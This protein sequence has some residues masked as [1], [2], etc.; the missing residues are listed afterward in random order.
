MAALLT[1]AVDRLRRLAGQTAFRDATDCQ[2][3]E[4]FAATGD[5]AAFAALVERHGS[6][7][8]G[9]CRRV[10]GHA[11]DA[12]DAFQATFLVLARKAGRLPWKESIKNWLH[13]VA[14]RV[15][16]KARCQGLRR[17]KKERAVRETAAAQ[18][19][20]ASWDDLRGV[21]DEELA[22]LPAKYRAPL[23]LCYLEGKTRDEAAEELGWTP[24]SVKGRLERGRDL[25][26][27]RL[28]A[29]GVPLSA[30]L[31]ASFLAETTASAAVPPT[32]AAATVTTGVSFSAGSLAAVSQPVLNLAQGVLNAMLIAKIKLS[33][34]ALTL[35]AV[36][37]L[38]GWA[39]DRAFADRG[40]SREEGLQLTGAVQDQEKPVQKE[41][42][43]KDKDA[44]KDGERKEKDGVRKKDGE[45]KEDVKKDRPREVSGIR[46]ILKSLDLAKGVMKVVGAGDGNRTEQTYNLAGKDVKVTTTTETPLKLSDLREGLMLFLQLNNQDDV[47][48]IQVELPRLFTFLTQVDAEKKQVTLRIEREQKTFA[49]APNAKLLIQ[50]REA[51]LE[52]FRV[53][54]KVQLQL[55]LDRGTV[56]AMSLTTKGPRDGEGAKG[57]REGEG[58]GRPH[59]VGF[60]FGV[61]PGADG[62]KL[63]VLAGEEGD[64]EPRTLLVPKDLKIHFK[65]ERLSQEVPLT[66]LKK[67]VRLG[68]WLDKD[69]KTVTRLEALAPVLRNA[70]I[71]GIDAG[72]KKI[73]IGE[74]TYTLAP[75]A[76]IVLGRKQVELA[77]VKEGDRATVVLSLDR[78]Q[79]I[80]LMVFRGDG[81]GREE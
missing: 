14:Y 29:R 67:G 52:D 11:H 15:A 28:L 23:L 81:E 1:T 58:P 36:L 73:T 61:Q 72:G 4:R 12:E 55:S 60:V 77:A 21:L 44:P 49:V 39:L 18:T 59:V 2:L 19:L 51:K 9:V 54:A 33:A 31:C 27:S 37:G 3:L 70:V 13:G 45:R 57:E 30:V 48:G 56:L 78:A 32:L 65:A 10:L 17:Q 7:V 40:A 71:K 64:L 26:R 41:G 6:L 75:E 34:V 22:R 63:E 53:G 24:G 46:V 43:R 68:I 69:K 42:V 47:T 16:L 50:G 38:G 79:I 80:A 20:E 74:K 25:L 5:E 35:V 62:A 66:E 8:L 76:Q